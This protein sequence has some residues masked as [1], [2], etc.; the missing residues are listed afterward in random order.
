MVFSSVLFLFLFLPAVITLYYCMYRM[1]TGVR[2]LLLLAASLLFYAWGEV[3][4]IYV[5]VAA[6]LVNYLYGLAFAYL[7]KEKARTA[8]L[9]LA[10]ATN[11]GLL[12]FYKYANFM[13][14]NLNL[15]LGW[16]GAAPVELGPVHLPIGISFFIFHSISYIVDTYR[17]GLPAAAESPGFGTVHRPVP[18]VGCRAHHP[19]PRYLRPVAAAHPFR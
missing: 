7:S 16:V 1:G 17:E 6:I 4:F 15:L 5:M 9:V 3:F 8:V 14:D 11:L 10:V 18:A 19:V 2:N 13:V 12:F